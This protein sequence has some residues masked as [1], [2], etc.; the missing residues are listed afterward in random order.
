MEKYLRL[1]WMPMLLAGCSTTDA[2]FVTKTSISVIDIDSTPASV[3]FAYDR[4]EGFFG[5]NYENGSAPSAVASIRTNGDIISPTIKQVYATGEAANIV[6]D[7]NAKTYPPGGDG[8]S[9]SD[10]LIGEKKP[11][12]FGTST[13]F[14]ISLGVTTSMPTFTLGYKRKEASYIPLRKSSDGEE[15]YTSVLASIDNSTVIDDNGQKFENGQFFAIGEAAKR[16]AT[17]QYIKDA[18]RKRAKDML[19]DFDAQYAKQIE[20]QSGIAR[21]LFGLKA[22]QWKAVIDSGI[23]ANLLEG[24]DDSIR[25]IYATYLSTEKAEDRI[26]LMDEYSNTIAVNIDPESVEYTALLGA[27]ETFVC[28]ITRENNDA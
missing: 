23:S 18:F 10:R 19:H 14:G 15:I 17:K 13:T 27:H 26:R 8:K 1:I 20:H 11:F 2:V 7:E 28:N 22:D 24:S 16:L 25:Q 21:C 9:D 5:P 12:M 4:V 6:V 3:S